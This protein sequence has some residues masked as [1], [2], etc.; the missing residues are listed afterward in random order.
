MIAWAAFALAAL[1][2][3]IVAWRL[4][5][6]PPLAAAVALLLGVAGWLALDAAVEAE[7]RARQ[8]EFRAAATPTDWATLS[9][10]QKRDRQATA[11]AFVGH[12]RRLGLMRDG[13]PLIAGLLVGG[14]LLVG[15]YRRW[16][17]TR[18][19]G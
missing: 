4:G 7:A 19:E 16:Q 18:L 9:A 14:G 6:R 5:R 13:A 1:A 17:A 8:T 11:D 2:P 12:G 3:P 10:E 15:A